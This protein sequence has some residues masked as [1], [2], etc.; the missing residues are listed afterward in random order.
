MGWVI[1]KQMN[2]THLICFELLMKTLLFNS[3]SVAN[4]AVYPPNWATLKSSAAGQK[5]VGRVA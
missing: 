3:S 5:T 2:V 1:A 4:A